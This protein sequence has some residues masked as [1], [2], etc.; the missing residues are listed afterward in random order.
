[1]LI[2]LAPILCYRRV[3]IWGSDRSVRIKLATW[4]VLANVC[5]FCYYEGM[6]RLSLGDFGAI[7]FSTPIFTMS[8]FLL[9]ERCGF[10][11]ITVSLLLMAG[12]I[13]IS[14]PPTLFGN[15]DIPNQ[16]NSTEAGEN[17]KKSSDIGCS[18]W[19]SLVCLDYNYCQGYSVLRLELNDMG[20]WSCTRRPGILWCGPPAHGST[21]YF[22]YTEQSHK[23]FSSC[24]FVHSTG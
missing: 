14:K 24:W 17:V 22:S 13:L 10:Y 19:I 3:S 15:E 16:G 5:V 12:I 1:M 8:V 6:I 20:V 21:I 2:L 11:R 7:A 18:G 9:Q 4:A 23:K